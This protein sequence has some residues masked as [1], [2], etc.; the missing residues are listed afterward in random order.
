MEMIEERVAALE[1]RMMEQ[2]QMFADIRATLGRLEQRTDDGFARVDR[3][4]DRIDARFDRIDD[5]F[6][7][8]DARL[9]NS[10][11]R[12]NTLLD[13]LDDRFQRIESRAATDFRWIVGIQMTTLVAVVAALLGVA[14]IR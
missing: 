3:Q 7:Q 2:S 9:A 8:I 14:I 6:V 10:D 5:R 11:D 1:G 4:F 13:R 12:F